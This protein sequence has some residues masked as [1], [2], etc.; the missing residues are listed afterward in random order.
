VIR[1]IHT[2]DWQIGKVFR[3]FGDK[4]ALFRQARL[5]AVET[6]GRLA[7]ERGVR[8]VLVAGDV[9]DTETPLGVTL[10]APVERMRAASTVTW[11]LL[12]GNHDPHRPKGLWEQLA[13]TDLPGNI[14][15]HLSAQPLEIEPGIVL[16]PAPL[17][18]KS[19]PNDLTRWMDEAPSAPGAIRIGLAH[20]SVAGF[21][22]EGEASNPIDPA[23][24]AKAG[25]AYLALG[26]W[27]RT[28]PIGERVWYAGT[29]EP[30]RFGSQEVGTALLVEI[31]GASA[32]PEVTRLT[33]GTYR[34]LTMSASLGDGT[35]IED[36]EARLRVLEG[37]PRLCLRLEASGL[38]SVEDRARFERMVEGVRAA[39]CHLDLAEEALRTRPSLADLDGID[40]DGVLRR[41]AGELKERLTAPGLAAEDERVTEAA[42]IA[43]YRMVEAT[44]EGQAPC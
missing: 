32:P 10:R 44:N 22:S 31:E 23:R 11:H 21:G 13:G 39:L 40:F 43:L 20:G 16:L 4:E 14:R 2:A 9:Y 7:R 8:H 6:I 3:R 26:D 37:L 42:L 15:L 25:L 1:F 33:T 27:H 24:P 18:R 19:E 29:P 38:L 41:V 5:D 12:P 17:Q 35:A 30:D 36:L 34:W 28:L